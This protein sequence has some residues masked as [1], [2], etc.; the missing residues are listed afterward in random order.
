MHRGQQTDLITE[1][2]IRPQYKKHFNFFTLSQELQ[3]I[4]IY[5][6]KP[7]L[8]CLIA[9]VINNYFLPPL[10]TLFKNI[11]LLALKWHKLPGLQSTKWS[12]TFNSMLVMPSNHWK[13]SFIWPRYPGDRHWHCLSRKNLRCYNLGREYGEFFFLSRSNLCKPKEELFFLRF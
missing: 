8:E 6:C 10:P 11:R 7:G 1:T 9:R 13:D 3:L 5:I 12:V 2:D 4:S